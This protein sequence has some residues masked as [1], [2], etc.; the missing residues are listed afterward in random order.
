MA[1]QTIS[2]SK[3]E[4]AYA[5]IRERIR[6]REYEPGYRLVLSTIAEA[7]EVSV[8]PVREAIRQLE[9]EGLVT[10]ERNVGARVSTYNQDVY[11]ETMETIAVLEGR[12]TALS[13]PL[14]ETEDLAQARAV[15]Q[16][17]R[18]LLEDFDPI[19]F[20]QLNKAFHRVLFGKCPNARL[21]QLLFDEWENLEY[22]RV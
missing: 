14:L 5:W 1:T 6:T 11:F 21:V 16:K 10:Y 2:K 20:T 4:T 17:M 3:A 18:D 12:A 9:A 13:A 7:L 15:N 19:E 8:V 22:F